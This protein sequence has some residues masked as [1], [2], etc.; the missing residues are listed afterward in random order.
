[1]SDTG[2]TDAQAT[3]T[4]AAAPAAPTLS[5][6]IPTLNRP[7]DLMIAVKTLLRQTHLPQELIIVD[8]SASDDSERQVR[9]LFAQRDAAATQF[10]LRYTRDPGIRSLA[11]AR[12]LLL[13]QN[14]CSI[15]LFLDDDVELEPDFVEKLLEGYAEDSAV[16]GISGIITNYKPGGFASRLWSRVFVHGPFLDER[17]QIYYRAAE[18]RSAGRIVVSRFGGG[19]MS[20]RTERIAGL[21]FDKNLKGSSEGEDVDFCLH[22]PAGARLEIDPRA[23][24]VHK[25]SITAR[26]NEHWIASVVRGSSY[27]YY[28]NWRKGLRNRTAFA[29]LMCGFAMLSLAASAR[30]LTLSPWRAFTTALAY[31]KSVGL[32]SN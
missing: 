17:Q 20:F 30:R 27:L 19:L 22:L 16:T 9:A 26:K 29:W 28:R 4:S 12:N 25:A 15:F 10:E 7:H 1:M 5:V 3:L 2:T 18:L 14:R 23:R 11:I 24:L 8:Q 32:S 6:L 13:D 31:G 21:R